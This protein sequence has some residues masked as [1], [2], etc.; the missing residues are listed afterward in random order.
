MP[1]FQRTDAS[2]PILPIPLTPDGTLAAPS[3]SHAGPS[4]SVRSNATDGGSAS[5]SSKIGESSGSASGSG[6]KL[7]AMHHLSSGGLSGFVSAVSLQPLDLL[8]TRVQ[9]AYVADSEVELVKGAKRCVLLYA[10][11]LTEV[12]GVRGIRDG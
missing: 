4:S 3:S 7:K 2:V 12:R 8:K 5:S 11:G 6:S 1:A 9:Q 10:R